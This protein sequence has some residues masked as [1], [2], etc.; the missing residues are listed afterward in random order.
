MRSGW[1]WIRFIFLPLQFNGMKG[2]EQG[3]HGTRGLGQH[4]VRQVQQ[5]KDG[6]LGDALS[7][8]GHGVSPTLH[9]KG[10]DDLQDRQNELTAFFSPEAVHRPTPVSHESPPDATTSLVHTVKSEE[11]GRGHVLCTL[12]Q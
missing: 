11:E 3:T 9:V 8:E 6:A 12:Q 4:L 7:H 1:G 5:A 10:G 2:I